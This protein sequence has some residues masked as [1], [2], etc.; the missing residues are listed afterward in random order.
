MEKPCNLLITRFLRTRRGTWT[1]TAVKPKDFKSFVSTIPPSGQEWF[2]KKNEILR[3]LCERKTGLPDVA[4][5]HRDKL[6][7]PFSAAFE[8]FTTLSEKRDSNPRPRPWQGRALPTELFSQNVFFVKWNRYFICFL[9][10]SA[11]AYAFGARSCS[12][13]WAIFAKYWYHFR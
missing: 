12:T 5:L 7:V 6:L 1:P 11:S 8:H 2:L 10:G 9:P 13:N 3:C 4:L